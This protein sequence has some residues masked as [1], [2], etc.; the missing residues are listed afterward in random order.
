M[1]RY[2]A[3]MKRDRQR[4]DV[5]T[6]FTRAPRRCYARVAP[7][8]R[9]ACSMPRRAYTALPRYALRAA[10][11]PRKRQARAC[12]RARAACAAGAL[13]VAPLRGAAALRQCA[14]RYARVVML[15]RGGERR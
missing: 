1:A 7:T 10:A 3:D 11:V 9:P 2:A 5:T 8:S 13:R 15:A 14:A 4:D 6:L 12:A